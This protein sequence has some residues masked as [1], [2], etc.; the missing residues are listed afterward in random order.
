MKEP[1]KAHPLVSLLFWALGQDLKRGSETTLH[2]ENEGD[3]NDPLQE[4]TL[5]WKDEKNGPLTTTNTW[6]D[7]FGEVEAKDIPLK[8]ESEFKG[9]L[10][11]KV[12]SKMEKGGNERTSSSDG[13]GSPNSPNNN[14]GFFVSITPPQAEI[15]PKK[16]DETQ[17]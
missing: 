13:G 17:K 9:P 15:F 16:K 4:R 10:K 6:I 11:P 3:T 7:D 5:S 2:S 14:W 1:L 8:G 12:L